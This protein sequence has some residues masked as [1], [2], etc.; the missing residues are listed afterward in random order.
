MTYVIL[1]RRNGN[2]LT[3]TSDL[4][5]IPLQ[6]VN[7]MSKFSKAPREVVLFCVLTLFY[8]VD[9]YIFLDLYALQWN[10]MTKTETLTYS[11]YIK[12]HNEGIFLLLKFIYDI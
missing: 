9:F 12:F 1:R 6:S 5:Q 10:H 4:H 7:R 2:L 8:S 3:T 11:Q